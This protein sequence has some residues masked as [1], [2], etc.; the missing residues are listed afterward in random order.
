MDLFLA[1][2]SRRFISKRVFYRKS[3]Q[4]SNY[5]RRFE[6]YFLPLTLR[7]GLKKRNAGFQPA[8]LTASCRQKRAPSFNVE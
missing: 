2:I 3:P 8:V 4:K 6:I 5:S 1:A 7:N